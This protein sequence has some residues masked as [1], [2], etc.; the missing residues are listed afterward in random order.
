MQNRC[1]RGRI[2]QRNLN[3]HAQT[4]VNKPPNLIGSTWQTQSCNF[5]RL[6]VLLRP[7]HHHPPQ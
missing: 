6:L 1:F 4:F 7:S 5:L 2:A 3:T